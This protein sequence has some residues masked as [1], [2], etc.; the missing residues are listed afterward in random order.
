MTISPAVDRIME[1]DPEIREPK[2]F[3]MGCKH[4]C[5]LLQRKVSSLSFKDVLSVVLKRK[6]RIQNAVPLL[7]RHAVM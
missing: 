3:I 6:S 5:P 4:A 7:I 2:S 1:G